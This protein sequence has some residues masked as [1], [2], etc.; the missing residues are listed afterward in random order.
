MNNTKYYNTKVDY[1]N[2]YKQN[3]YGNP[4]ILKYVKKGSIVFDVGCNTGNLAKGL[5]EIKNCK[6]YGVDISDKALEIASKYL[7]DYKLL[8]LENFSSFPFSHIN[9]DYIVLAD[10]LEHIRN[11][12]EVLKKIQDQLKYK[13]VI[14]S[15]PNVAFITIRL[16]LLIGKFDY[17]KQ[18]IMDESHLHF[19]T[20]K[21]MIELFTN[22]GFK[23]VNC[24]PFPLTNK[25]FSFITHP[26][27][28]LFPTLFG[29]QLVWTLIKN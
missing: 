17:K 20:K 19:Y 6:I 22:A 10:V 16:K 27:T 25:K 21:T 28:K 9:F 7:A 2:L 23:I 29:R 24:T 14:V 4:L 1:Y 12:Y 8:D 18:G 26:L 13:K 15:L 3:N 5:T 11:P